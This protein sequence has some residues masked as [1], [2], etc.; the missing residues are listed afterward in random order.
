MA[1]DRLIATGLIFALVFAT[2]AYGAVEPWS[3][4]IVEL[5]VTATTLLWA[6]KMA[7]DHEI[8]IK[9]PATTYPIAALLAVA[10]IQCVS[11]RASDGQ[12]TSLSDDVEA[13]RA[14]TVVL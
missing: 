11:F 14:T 9:L 13:T 4:A 3:I 2:L 10:L 5:I 8:D 6:L 1:L 12:V 7:G